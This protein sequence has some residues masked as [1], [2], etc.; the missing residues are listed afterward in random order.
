MTRTTSCRNRSLSSIQH[1][2][3]TRAD[4]QQSQ[5]RSC[6]PSCDVALVSIEIVE[7]GVAVGG[8][9]AA[10][11]LAVVEDPTSDQLHVDVADRSILLTRGDLGSCRLERIAVV[12]DRPM[13]ESAYRR[14]RGRTR[15]SPPWPRDLCSSA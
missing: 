12:L 7:L 15:S 8:R 13:P 2:G 3:A 14:L 9:A 10:R 11:Q 4:A 1:P 6:H 5:P